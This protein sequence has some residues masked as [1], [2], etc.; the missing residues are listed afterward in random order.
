MSAADGEEVSWSATFEKIVS[1]YC[2][3]GPFME[4]GA[5]RLLPYI[6]A[7][8]LGRAVLELGPNRH[9][10]VTPDMFDGRIVY[11]ELSDPCVQF[12]RDKFGDAVAVVKFNLHRAW[13]A[14]DNVLATHLAAARDRDQKAP[15]SF[16]SLIVSQVVNYVDFRMLLQACVTLLAVDGLLFFNNV[17][18]HGG[19][20]LFH[21]R[22]PQT[23]EEFLEGAAEIGFDPIEVAAEPAGPTDIRH[24]AVLRR[25]R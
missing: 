4:A 13:D 15:V 1:T 11:V 24:L 16:D 17:M 8:G 20:S 23:M 2:M 12:L 9:P 19:P 7:H 14:G 6:E 18:N 5:R 3:I 22:R 25:R 21:P 10:L